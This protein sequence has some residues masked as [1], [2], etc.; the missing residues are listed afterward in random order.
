MRPAPP[1][2]TGAAGCLP[3]APACLLPVPRPDMLYFW[4]SN[5]DR[6][7]ARLLMERNFSNIRCGAARW[8]GACRRGRPQLGV[9]GRQPHTPAPRLPSGHTDHRPP[10]R[11]HARRPLTPTPNPA[12][13][14]VI[15]QI[16]TAFAPGGLTS[17]DGRVTYAE[18]ARLSKV[19]A[20][21]MFVVGDMD[22]M[23]PPDGA[24][25]LSMRPSCLGES[26]AASFCRGFQDCLKPL[27]ALG[28]KRCQER[29]SPAAASS[30]PAGSR[31]ARPGRCLAAGTRC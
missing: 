2:P 10:S 14:G 19:T 26:C 5:V 11:P 7:V 4:P 12:S 9:A 31:S 22:R 20:P 21:A 17:S 13:V 15:R 3:S 16:A 25:S 29:T 1:A 8:A 18:A 23:C 30:H 6:R 27:G 28:D 24:V